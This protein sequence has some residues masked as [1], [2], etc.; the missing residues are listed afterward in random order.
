ML[1]TADAN[2]ISLE[3]GSIVER[4]VRKGIEAG[5]EDADWSAFYE[6]T[7]REAGLP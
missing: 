4:K 2:G 3:T 6:I 1:S 7:R 5:M